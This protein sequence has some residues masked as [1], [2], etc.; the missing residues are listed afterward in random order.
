VHLTDGDAVVRFASQSAAQ[1]YLVEANGRI[2]SWQQDRSTMQFGLQAYVPLRFAL[3][4]V[5]KCRV[6]G[7]GRPLSGVAQGAVTRY[8]LKQNGIQRITVTCAAN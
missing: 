3:A 1:P 7:D 2:E 4:N 6:E 5:S 8:E